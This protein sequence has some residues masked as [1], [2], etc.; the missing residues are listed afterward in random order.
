MIRLSQH[1][2]PALRLMLFLNFCAP[3]LECKLCRQRRSPSC[4]VVACLMTKGRGQTTDSVVYARLSF[5]PSTTLTAVIN[6]RSFNLFGLV[7]RYT[8]AS[9]AMST[10]AP[11]WQTDDL[12][13]EWVES[14][15][16]PPPSAT[17][18]SLRQPKQTGTS[19]GTLSRNMG[20]IQAKRGSLRGLGH[21]PAR[22]LP[23]SRSTSASDKMMAKRDISGLLSPPE[24]EP[25]HEHEPAAEPAELPAGTCL[26]REGV[27]DDRGKH[28]VRNQ[29]KGKDIFGALPLER[30]FLPP[31]P[32]QPPAPTVPTQ[33][34]PGPSTYQPH[35]PS[36]SPSLSPP[37]PAPSMGMGVADDTPVPRRISHQYAPLQPSR[38]SKS[39]TPSNVS[40]SFSTSAPASEAHTRDNTA[41]GQDDSVLQDDTAPQMEQDQTTEVY[42]NHGQSTTPDTSPIREE[43]SNSGLAPHPEA[44]P[45]SEFSFVYEPP[46]QMQAGSPPAFD[47]SEISHSTVYAGRQPQ[48]TDQQPGLRLFRSTYDTYT[49]EHL[50]AL[51]D[52]IAIEQSH[53]QSPSQSAGEAS[54]SSRDRETT[55]ARSD[56]TASSD[57]RSSKRLR[58]S[59]PSPPKRT[60]MRDWGAQGR[61]MMDKIRDIAPGSATSASRS[62]TSEEE[63]RGQLPITS[64]ILKD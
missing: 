25:E 3:P 59:P 12:G 50:S 28:L 2:H 45:Q 7:S 31:S 9:M 64:S 43:A 57:A 11:G 8:P 53:S 16:S 42:Y 18:S 17:G 49:R 10:P 41:A 33:A 30:M 55:P 46:S 22:G 24:S 5:R 19:T 62:R 20:S 52:S 60:P 63:Q 14:S 13:E 56:E 40:S 23:P 27:D 37:T 32:P 44:A 34:T 54:S 1:H 35:Q 38:L 6:S 58:L 4:H 47:P 15:P 26:V 39:I 36:P 29:S 51:V 61:S 48:S 21:A